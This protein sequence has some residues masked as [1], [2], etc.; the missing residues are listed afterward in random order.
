MPLVVVE[1]HF[2]RLDLH[3]QLAISKVH[4]ENHSSIAKSKVQVV[5]AVP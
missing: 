5:G 1:S 2:V 3:F 4:G